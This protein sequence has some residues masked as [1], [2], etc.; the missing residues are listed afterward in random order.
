MT[1]EKKNKFTEDAKKEKKNKCSY[2]DNL[3]EKKNKFTEDAKKEKKNKCSYRD[4]L[5]T[6]RTCSIF[7]MEK[8]I[9]FYKIYKKRNVI[10][11]K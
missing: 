10:Y 5:K 6:I 7:K 11:F 9:N 3:K 1:Q 4:N 2:R 8:H